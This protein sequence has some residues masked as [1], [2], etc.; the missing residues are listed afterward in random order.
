MSNEVFKKID[1]LNS[2]PRFSRRYSHKKTKTCPIWDGFKGCW[3]ESDDAFR[4]R[5][6]KFIDK[7]SLTPP[8][9]K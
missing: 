3:A 5:I 9:K 7:K 1:E 2:Q 8:P 4:K 6:K